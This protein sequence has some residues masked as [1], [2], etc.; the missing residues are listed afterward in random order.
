MAPAAETGQA[1]N[2]HDAG[3]A[4][5]KALDNSEQSW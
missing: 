2:G 1:R 4:R 5:L 3:N